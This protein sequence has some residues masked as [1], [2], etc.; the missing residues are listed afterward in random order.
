M[1]VDPAERLLRGPFASLLDA[2]IVAQRLTDGDGR[3]WQEQVDLRGRPLGSPS[4]LPPLSEI[5]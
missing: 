2:I 4:L 1:I 5:A 3:V